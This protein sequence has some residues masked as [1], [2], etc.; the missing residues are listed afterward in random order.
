M[1]C[2][3]G[4]LLILLSVVASYANPQFGFGYPPVYQPNY[5]YQEPAIHSFRIANPY[6]S[7]E[8]AP[9]NPED[10]FFLGTATLTVGTTTVTSTVTTSTTCT[11]ATGA[12]SICSPS[13]RRR[14]G[15]NAK[16]RGLFYT[17]DEDHFDSI[18]VRPPWVNPFNPFKSYLPQTYCCIEPT[19]IVGLSRKPEVSAIEDKLQERETP[20]EMVPFVVQPGFSLPDGRQG[21][22][23][24]ALGTKSI[25]TTTT[26]TYTAILT[27]LCKSTTA[28]ST[29]SGSG[30]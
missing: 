17:E 14:R 13:G 21:R 8:K 11:T 30:K 28:F 22:F 4:C 2:A 29:C 20:N 23:L 24:V 9:Q 1:Y 5:G 27:A 26:S 10:R 7:F 19:V 16:S 25:T 6:P 15:L 18:F 12:I 3:S